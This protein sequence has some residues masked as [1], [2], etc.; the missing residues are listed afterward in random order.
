MMMYRLGGLQKP[1]TD[2]KMPYNWSE[3]EIAL[4]ANA[5]RYIKNGQYTLHCH[6]VLQA[7]IDH[8]PSS[9]AN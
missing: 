1:P 3:R 5:S 4:N 7:T 9:F 2:E 8:Q 6:H